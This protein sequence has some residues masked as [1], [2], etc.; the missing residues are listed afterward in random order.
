MSI[1][2]LEL[3]WSRKTGAFYETFDVLIDIRSLAGLGFG[4][5]AKKPGKLKQ[6]GLSAW[7]DT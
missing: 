4:M 2:M 5:I 6:G 7:R 1:S 3:L